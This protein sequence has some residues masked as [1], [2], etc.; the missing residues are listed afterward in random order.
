MSTRCTAATVGRRA[1]VN[2]WT[3]WTGQQLQDK[4]HTGNDDVLYV[5]ILKAASFSST[6]APSGLLLLACCRFL[7]LTVSG[8][9]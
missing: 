4:E 6:S 9:P 8:I 1:G 5:N 3:S 2:H 7:T